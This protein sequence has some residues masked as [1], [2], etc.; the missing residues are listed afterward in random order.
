MVYEL[1]IEHTRK[2]TKYYRIELG[3]LQRKTG[4]LINHTVLQYSVPA[5]NTVCTD[6]TLVLN[7]VL[8]V[9]PSLFV[10]Q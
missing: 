3:L 6:A 9:I 1:I 2:I 4:S 7:Q 5:F 8:W 10:K